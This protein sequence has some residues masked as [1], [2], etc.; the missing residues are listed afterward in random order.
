M[1]ILWLFTNRNG[2]HL[3]FLNSKAVFL[4]QPRRKLE[5]ISDESESPEESDV[6]RK[7]KPTENISSWQ[8]AVSALPELSEKPAEAVTPQKTGP[9][10]AESSA[11]K[12]T[13]ATGRQRVSVCHPPGEGRRLKMSR[14]RES[15]F[16][17]L[18][19]FW[20]R[21]FYFSYYKSLFTSENLEGIGWKVKSFN[22]I[23][24]K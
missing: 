17:F 12:V 9:Q 11:E 24:P 16:F 2:K 14:G 3:Y 4:I 22:S 23:T 18:H 1:W 6:R 7:V 15:I 21:S 5:P 8:G 10:S 20:E 13:L 19:F